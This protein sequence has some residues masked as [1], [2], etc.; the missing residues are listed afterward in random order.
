MYTVRSTSQKTTINNEAAWVYNNYDVRGALAGYYNGNS[1]GVSDVIVAMRL[2]EGPPGTYPCG[3]LSYRHY[4]EWRSTATGGLFA[5]LGQATSITIN[6]DNVVWNYLV[7]PNG[8]GYTAYTRT[9]TSTVV[10]LPPVRAD[11]VIE[12]A[13]S[14]TSMVLHIGGGQISVAAANASYIEQIHP[15]SALKY[16]VSSAAFDPQYFVRNETVVPS[17]PIVRFGSTT[18]PIENQLFGWIGVV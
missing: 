15:A 6:P 14:E 3:S 17:K 11:T 10:D 16:V 8:C 13:T 7:G 1:D 9:V 18:Y 2:A 12:P 5:W 4:A